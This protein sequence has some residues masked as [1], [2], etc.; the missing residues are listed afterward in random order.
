MLKIYLIIV[1]A[2]ALLL[3]LSDK[4]FARRKMWRIPEAALIGIAVIGGSVGALVGMYLFRHKTKHMKF[5][6]GIPLI[7]FAQVL[8]WILIV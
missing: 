6:I 3:M 4:S 5:V 1:N 7:L 8:L 2:V